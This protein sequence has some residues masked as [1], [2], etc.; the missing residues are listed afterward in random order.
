MDEQKKS[1]Y[2]RNGPPCVDHEVIEQVVKVVVV[3]VAM[4]REWNRMRC[5]AM[6]LEG[7]VNIEKGL[8]KERSSD[9]SILWA[10]A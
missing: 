7:Y 1:C 2:F 10:G 8:K 3:L 4:V 9:Q 6:Q 5:D